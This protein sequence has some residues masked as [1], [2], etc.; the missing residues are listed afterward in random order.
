MRKCRFCEKEIQASSVVCEHCGKSLIAGRPDPV[1]VVDAV[2]PTIEQRST[3]RCP[4]C[5]EE[6]QS[7]AVLCKHCGS[8]V[9]KGRAAARGPDAAVVTQP[10]LSSGIA[11]LLSLVIPGGGQMYCG[12]VGV[13]MAW[14]VFVIL[15]YVAFILPGIVLHLVCI[16]TASA[17]ATD[18][19]AA[20]EAKGRR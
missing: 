14:F 8:D 3:K 13:G 6:I 17:M 10:E 7:A 2:A 11:A 12:R 18:I 16:G 9:A 5:A 15:G 4:F 19:N 1:P 20:R